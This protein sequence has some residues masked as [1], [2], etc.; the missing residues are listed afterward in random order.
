MILDAMSRPNPFINEE[1]TCHLANPEI[2]ETGIL[3]SSQAVNYGLAEAPLTLISTKKAVSREIFI[4]FSLSLP[5]R[6]EQGNTPIDY[7]AIRSYS[8]EQGESNWQ[9]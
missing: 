2:G 9:L 4:C 8:L 3:T 1:Y 7:Q 5:D 6:A